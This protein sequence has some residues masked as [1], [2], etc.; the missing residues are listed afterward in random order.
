MLKQPSINT[1]SLA[2][3]LGDALDGAGHKWTFATRND[4]IS[5]AYDNACQVGSGGVEPPT[6]ASVARRSIH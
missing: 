4:T 5:H 6:S 2:S 3:R 1:Q